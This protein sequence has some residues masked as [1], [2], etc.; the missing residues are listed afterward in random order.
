MRTTML[1]G[2]AFLMCGCGNFFGGQTAPEPAQPLAQASRVSECRG[3]LAAN[4]PFFADGGLGTFPGGYCDAE[5][6]EWR[7][8]ADQQKLSLVDSR[9]SLNCC[10][11]LAMSLEVQEGV[12]V[13][14][15]TDAP[16]DG[17]YGRCRCDCIF[18]L[19]IEIEHVPGGVIELKLLRD[20]T[21]S[22]PVGTLWTGQV[23]LSAGAGWV[24]LSTEGAGVCQEIMQDQRASQCGG[25][26]KNGEPVIV[27]DPLTPANYCDAGVMYWA[28]EGGGT[29]KVT[30]TRVLLNCCGQRSA[31]L[32]LQNGVYVMTEIDNPEVGNTRCHCECVFDLG[33]EASVPV[34]VIDFKL[35]RW[36]TDQDAA[37]VLVWQGQLDLSAGSGSVTVDTSSTEAICQEP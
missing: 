29:L 7:Y 21:D 1:I 27:G 12:Y 14:T 19:G 3:F 32:S 8:Q 34:G 13:F 17:E 30:D 4:E 23:D 26:V 31:S 9:M 5:V 2:L 15:E 22:P 36:V 20:T 11:A 28:H 18:D 35:M 25:F 6:L 37:P 16:P 33:V 24:V 10:S